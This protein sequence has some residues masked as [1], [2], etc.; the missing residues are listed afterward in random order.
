MT[1]TQ[2]AR[3]V[4]S[5]LA[6]RAWPLALIASAVLAAV[7]GG[8][9][10]DVGA[11]GNTA[12]EELAVM[13]A[14]PSWVPGHTLLA[15]S[16]ALLALGLWG[17]RRSGRWPRADRALKVGVVAI[18]LYLVEAVMHTAAA[19][20]SEA[21]AHGHSAPVAFT[22]LGLAAFLYPAS[23]AAIVWMAN[24]IGAEWGRLRFL[25]VLGIVGGCVHAV[26]VPATLLLPET[27]TTPLFAIAGTT[28]AGWTLAVG[29]MGLRRPAAQQRA[30]L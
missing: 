20:D 6:S 9:H 2:H 5:T 15:I 16:V 12:R 30:A 21:L 25:S 3:P 1:T 29:V 4:R 17:A 8:M 23:G 11:E 7:G 13:T 10:P 19:V 27:E 26:V 28:I 14:D 24:A 22:H 18:C